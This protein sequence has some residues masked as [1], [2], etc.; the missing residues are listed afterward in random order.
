MKAIAALLTGVALLASALPARAVEAFRATYD[1][2]RSGRALGVATLQVVP[3]AGRWRIDLVM[4]GKGLI[5]LAGLNA[6]QSTVFDEVN[7]T[8]RPLAQSTVRKVLFTRKQTT[9]VYDWSARRATWT[10]DLK[11]SRKAP[12]ALE[13]GDLSALL[14]DL[15]L[16]RD[17]RP[18]AV[19]EY[20]VV[21]NGRARPQRWQ[22]GTVAEDVTIGEL[23]FSAYRVDRVQTGGDQTSIW[24]AE[25]GPTP[26]RILQ[27]EN[28]EDTYDLRLTGYKGA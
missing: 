9:G 25:G 17:A 6:Q 27:R 13:P 10:G 8:F 18:G 2:Y 19:L 21:D 5:G 24:V 7:G 1:V 11:D 14:V 23:P 20:R 15:A 22:V 3:D 12:V 16:I 26:V 4:D 28:G